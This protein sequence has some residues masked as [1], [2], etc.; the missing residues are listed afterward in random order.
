MLGH[1]LSLLISVFFIIIFCGKRFPF[2]YKFDFGKIIKQ[3]KRYYKFPLYTFPQSLVNLFSAHLPVIV[4]QIYYTLE[5]VG[6]YFFS[7]KIVQ[8]PAMFIGFSIRQVFYKEAIVLKNDQKKLLKLFNKLNFYLSLIIILPTIILF[9]YSGEIFSFVFGENWITAGHFSAWM[10][11]WFG[12]NIIAGPS[13]SLF[14]VFEE[15]QK[16]FYV[17]MLL[18]ICRVGALIYLSANYLPIIVIK[19]ISILSLFFNILVIIYFTLKLSSYKLKIIN[20]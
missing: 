10:M 17:D 14:L 12:S 6:F 11:L 15:Q 16:V 20:D 5:I 19:W 8:I 3:A 2:L 4:L 7:L 18:L 1:V 9:L 13:R